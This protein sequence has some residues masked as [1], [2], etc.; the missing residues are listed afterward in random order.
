MRFNALKLLARNLF[1]GGL[2]RQNQD[3]KLFLIPGD[4]MLLNTHSTSQQPDI[5][6]RFGQ[7]GGKYVR[8]RS[9]LQETLCPQLTGS[10]R[11]VISCSGRGDKNVQ[12][13]AKFLNLA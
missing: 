13:V 2:T 11:I 4:S 8:T 9:P 10:P 5:L 12:T 7:F 3:L 6:G 1:P